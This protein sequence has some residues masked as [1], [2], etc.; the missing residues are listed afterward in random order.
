MTDIFEA[1]ENLMEDSLTTFNRRGH[2]RRGRNGQL[3]W[4]SSHSVSRDG[5]QSYPTSVPSKAPPHPTPPKASPSSNTRP[6]LS[7]KWAKPNANCP[8]CGARVYF[9]SNE[10]GS[11][12]YFDEIGP[13]WPKHPCMDNAA[14]KA[15][16]YQGQM[17]N[18]PVPY[19]FAQGRHL[20]L[21]SRDG[22][23][24][25]LAVSSRGT[26]DAGAPIAFRVEDSTRTPS[27][28]LLRLQRLYELP[29]PELWETREVVSLTSGQLVFIQDDW[30]S[31]FDTS[32]GD[33]VRFRVKF[34][35][36]P[37]KEAAHESPPPAQDVAT[38][39]PSP[40]TAV[41]VD[42]PPAPRGVVDASP[43]PKGVASD[44]KSPQRKVS[45]LQ[46]LLDK[47]SG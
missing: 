15:M 19:G 24:Q 34:R 17:K 36:M 16:H 11:R 28:T 30:L 33:V 4:V 6:H 22:G 23:H 37:P 1:T 38:N 46:R 9:Y 35:P 45:L 29:A 31:L 3:V 27:G 21:K 42:A 14:A 7:E 10:A 2:Y 44:S 26:K 12:V 13:P 8:V 43:R 20:L 47:L 32:L 39:A 25:N 40:A 41:V 18:M 5:G